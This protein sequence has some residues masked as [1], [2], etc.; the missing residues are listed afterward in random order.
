MYTGI[1]TV[2]SK[3]CKHLAVPLY[4]FKGTN[5]INITG[6]GFVSITRKA[7]GEGHRQNVKQQNEKLST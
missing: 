2:R 5:Q 4:C 7:G 6:N 1:D 3:H